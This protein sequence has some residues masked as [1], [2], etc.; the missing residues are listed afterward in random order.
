MRGD[1]EFSEKNKRIIAELATP[2]RQLGFEGICQF[3]SENFNLKLFIATPIEVFEKVTIIAKMSQ[4]DA[5]FEVAYNNIAAG[6]QVML[7]LLISYKSKHKLFRKRR[8]KKIVESKAVNCSFPK[9]KKNK[10]LLKFLEKQF[11]RVNQCN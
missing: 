8:T 5:N 3:Y 6:V 7:F 2:T 11:I 4:E 10:N 9:K 1:F